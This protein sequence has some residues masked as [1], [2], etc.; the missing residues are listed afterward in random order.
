[1][2]VT[3]YDHPLSPYGQKVKIALAEKGVPFQAP[4]PQDIGSGSASGDFA[5]AS[6]RGEVPAL[7][8]T[9]GTRVFDSTVILEYVEDR[10]P[11]PPL[12]PASPAERARVRMLE[13]VMD[14]HFEAITWGLSEI[15][16]F[17][18]ATGELAER[19]KAK[20]AEQMAGWMGWLASQLGERPW[21]NGD[22]FGWGDLCVVP[23]LNGAAGFGFA[24]E[25]ALGDWQ[26]R[27]NERPSVAA[28]AKAALEAAAQGSGVGLEQ[29]RALLDQGLFKREY[30]DHR[31]EWMVKTG[32]LEVV[33]DGIEKGN[34][35]FID[36]FAAT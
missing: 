31:L 15:E 27:A 8:D 30:R 9:D 21:F 29:V 14:T 24:A 12:L 5:Q 22:A 17:G 2:S 4:L 35:R 11:D 26:R 28:A 7:V 13:D 33:A 19:M 18:R 6:P 34:V 3:I 16:Y 25:G 1:M 32:G 20:A 10:W 36:P 23:F